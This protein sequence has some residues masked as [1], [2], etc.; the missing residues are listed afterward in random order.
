M[1]YKITFGYEQTF[2]K[3]TLFKIGPRQ[4]TE[5]RSLKEGLTGFRVAIRFLHHPPLKDPSHLEF[6]GRPPP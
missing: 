6:R 3:K 1:K 2:F 4:A 5:R